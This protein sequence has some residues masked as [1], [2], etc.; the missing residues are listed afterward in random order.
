[1]GAGQGRPLDAI[2]AALVAAAAEWRGDGVLDVWTRPRVNEVLSYGFTSWCSMNGC[3]RP[4]CEPEA[5]WS[6]ALPRRHGPADRRVG[7]LDHLLEPLQCYGGLAATAVARHPVLPTSRAVLLPV[8][9]PSRPG[10]SFAKAYD[11][12]MIELWRP[13]RSQPELMEWYGPL[14]RFSR[15]VRAESVCM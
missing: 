12:T 10:L 7:R 8:V 9:V 5:L 3:L 2:L 1:V 13:L 11:D 4:E 6:P 14:A 15:A